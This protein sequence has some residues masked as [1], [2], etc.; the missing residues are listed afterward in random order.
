MLDLLKSIVRWDVAESRVPQEDLHQLVTDAV[1]YLQTAQELRNIKIPD[2]YLFQAPIEFISQDRRA[3]NGTYF[4]GGIHD[5]PAFHLY[6][7]DKAAHA[8]DFSRIEEIIAREIGGTL[9]KK[10]VDSEAYRINRDIN[11][12]NPLTKTE[13]GEFIERLRNHFLKV[14]LKHVYFFGI[15]KDVYESLG[16][17][18]RHRKPYFRRHEVANPT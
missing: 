14:E 6:S 8:E 17:P 10:V 7:G 11:L 12:D 15:P 5:K 1:L 18:E 13:I 9:G 16:L 2:Q 3:Y 4:S